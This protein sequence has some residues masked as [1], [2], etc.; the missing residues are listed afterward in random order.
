LFSEI[1]QLSVAGTGERRT[2]VPLAPSSAR[3]ANQIPAEP[4][5]PFSERVAR[6]VL[7]FGWPGILLWHVVAEGGAR[8]LPSAARWLPRWLS[9]MLGLSL[10]LC[11]R[12]VRQFGRHVVPCL[13]IGGK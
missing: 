3:M 12:Q 10:G 9:G 7:G 13:R 1:L 4:G 2:I 11:R 5:K 8:H 6:N